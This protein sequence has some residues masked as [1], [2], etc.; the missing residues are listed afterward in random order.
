MSICLRIVSIA[1]N[2]FFPFFPFFSLFF[3]FFSF[4]SPFFLFFPLFPFFPFFPFFFLFFP[5]FSFF[6]LFPLPYPPFPPSPPFSL[7]S[8]FFF[9]FPLF[10]QK[11]VLSAKCNSVHWFHL[12]ASD[13]SS[14]P[15][16][17]SL[18]EE[19]WI[20]QVDVISSYMDTSQTETWKYTHALLCL[21]FSKTDGMKILP[22]RAVGGLCHLFINKHPFLGWSSRLYST[23][24]HTYFILLVFT[25]SSKA[26]EH[27]SKLFS[28]SCSLFSW[29]YPLAGKL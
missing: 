21:S 20:C 23:Q 25:P 18:P 6:F 13:A 9:F 24:T 28:A 27:F 5:P 7:F 11:G 8:P 14:E 26:H 29:C 10:F 16:Q 1:A 19:D 17:S 22:Q 3:L 2:S 15:P 12:L 4:F